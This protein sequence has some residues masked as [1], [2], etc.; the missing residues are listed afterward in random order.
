MSNACAECGADLGGLTGSV[1]MTDAKVEK[2]REWEVDVP[3]PICA[4]C[5]GRVLDGAQARLGSALGYP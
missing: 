2:L 5:F 3:T 4:A 1:E